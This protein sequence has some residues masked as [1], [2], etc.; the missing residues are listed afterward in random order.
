MD[1]NEGFFVNTPPADAE[2]PRQ[3]SPNLEIGYRI[4]QAQKAGFGDKEIISELAKELPNV[5]QAL[6]AGFKPT[7]IVNEYLSSSMGV[8]EVASR[9]ISN[10]PSSFGSMVGNVV[11]A[12]TSPVQ[13]AKSVLDLGA[14]IL[15]NVL[16]ESLVQAV[17]EDKASRE[18]ASKVGQ[19]YADRYGSVEG[20]KRAI[21]E[22]PVG[23][24]ADVS[25]ILTGGALAGPRAVSQPLARVASAIDPLAIAGRGVLRATELGGRG[26]A[27]VLGLTTG[28]GKESIT[29][30]F[31]AGQRGGEAA[32]QF[33]ANISGRADPTEVLSLA[34]ANL[35]EMNRLKQTEYRSGM[36]N[37]KKDKT[38]LDFA[39]I[40]KALENAFNRVTYKG[41]V[42]NA[43]AAEKI[44]EVQQDVAQ[45]KALDPNEFHTPEGLDA[46]KQKIGD[47]LESVP[48][49]QKTARASIGEIYNS[50]KSSIQKQAPT[51]ANTMREYSVASEQIREIERALS[52]GKGA[53]VDT[54]MRKLQSLMRNNVQTNYGSRTKL[55]QQLEKVGGQEFMPGLAGQAL[56]SVTPRGL[57]TATAIPTGALAYG[58]GGLP[59]AGLSLLAASPRAVGEA[60]YGAGALGRGIGGVTRR[61]PF[62]IDPRT[63]NALFQAGQI[64]GQTE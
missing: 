20:A 64:Q 18:V 31:E 57:Q 60:A 50:V 10:I 63:F 40:D 30:A 12:V 34:K 36:V 25:T 54:A 59:S 11:E 47:T 5:N 6:K 9:A 55:A 19:F 44:T 26:V 56:S 48:F 27:N 35:D 38:V 16:P 17:G 21:A 7:D 42:K 45:W 43:K 3:S 33:R 37:I 13:T 15:Q 51:Y 58:I 1:E 32:E 52:L 14:G 8:G 2:V 29:K 61:A 39:D 22:D 28:A 4:R 23:V 24:L 53:S 62:I 41:Q 49:E 46:L